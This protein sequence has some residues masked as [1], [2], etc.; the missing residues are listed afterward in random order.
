MKNLPLFL[1]CS[2]LFS[3]CFFKNLNNSSSAQNDLIIV[4]LFNDVQVLSHDNMTGRETGTSG[5]KKAAKYIAQRFYDLGLMPSGSLEEKVQNN[6]QPFYQDFIAYESSDPHGMTDMPNEKKPVSARNVIGLIDNNAPNTIV[7]GGHYDHLG[8]G[9]FGSLYTGPAEIHNGADDNASGIAGMLYLA[10]ELLKEKYNTSNYLCIAFSGEEK[11]LWGSNYWTKNPTYPLEKLN[12]MINFDMIGR[13]EDDKL[14]VNG[15][16]TSPSWNVIDDVS[17]NFDL[18][19]SESGIGPSDH[20]SFY[21]ID[22]PVLHFFTGQHEDYHRPSDDVELLNFKGIKRV[23]DL[24]LNITKKINGKKIAF[25]K[26]KDEEI[27]VSAFKVTLGVIP[28]YLFTDEGMRIDG[29]RDGKTAFEAGIEKGDIV[30]KMG[31]YEIVDMKT[32]MESLAKFEPGQSTT[33]VVSRKGK[34]L[35]KEVTFQ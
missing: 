13:L 27:K 5:E 9:N 11:G 20:S 10:E 34:R 16:G 23:C 12:F 15:V 2:L 30:L 7:I 1:F 14:A 19:K 25:T 28:D 3:S 32:Y 21:L 31:E 29:V 8:Y 17:S 22:I 35:E 18:V 4:Q 24:V 33:V 26:T 6:L